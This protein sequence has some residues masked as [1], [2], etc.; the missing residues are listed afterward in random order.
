MCLELSFDPS[1]VRRSFID[2]ALRICGSHLSDE[3]VAIKEAH[4]A[5]NYVPKA[6]IPSSLAA[7]TVS[8]QVHFHVVSANNTLQGGNVPYELHT[9]IILFLN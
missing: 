2:L 1:L 6:H 8:V 9:I 7:Q 4:Y 3:E 5:A